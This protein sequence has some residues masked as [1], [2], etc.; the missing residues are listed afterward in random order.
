MR[1]AI[2]NEPSGR[3]PGGSEYLVAVLAEALS[4]DHDVELVHHNALLTR[5]QLRNFTGSRLET[6]AVSCVPHQERSSERSA[7]PWVRY[8]QARAWHRTLSAGRDL[9]IN[10]THGIPPFCAARQGVLL[11]LF[12]FSAPAHLSPQAGDRPDALRRAYHTWEWKRRLASY[13]ATI[14]ISEYTQLWTLRRWGVDS[15]VVHPPVQYV[16]A[17]APKGPLVM[18]VGRFSGGRH[19][20][21]QEEMTRT[22]GELV[23]DGFTGWRYLSVGGVSDAAVDQDFLRRVTA[24]A[25]GFPIT[26]RCNAPRDELSSHY[27]AAAIFWHAAGYGEPDDAPELAEHF[28]ISTVEAMAAGCVP[29]VINRGGQRE[30]VEHGVTGFLWNTLGELKHYTLLVARDAAL[31]SRVAEAARQRAAC[32]TPDRFVARFREAVAAQTVT[33]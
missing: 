17:S 13:Q 10:V 8:R 25:A 7:L 30:I 31:R 4:R 14:S 33:V 29:I 16:S 26:I 28:G 32:F 19:S 23:R 22:F 1:I 12:P 20:K 15:A 27:A 2:Y 18:S 3:Q 6:V 24:E 9:F 11:V 21:R 5:E